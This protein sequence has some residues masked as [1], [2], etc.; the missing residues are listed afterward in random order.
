M[1]IGKRHSFLILILIEIYIQCPHC[2]GKMG[3]HQSLIFRASD[4]IRPG[5]AAER[6]LLGVML[7]EPF[8]K[9]YELV[10]H[11]SRDPPVQPLLLGRGSFS[12]VYKC[13]NKTTSVVCALKYVDTQ[14]LFHLRGNDSVKRTINE[15]R[16][17]VSVL[18]QLEHQNIIKLHDYY[19][20]KNA[21]AVVLEC[22]GKELYDHVVESGNLTERDAAAI[23]RDIVQAVAYMHKKGLVH[24]DLKP[25][26]IVKCGNI[27]K[28][29]DFGFS[30]SINI[31][32]L[33]SF[34]GTKNYA[35]PEIIRREA[36]DKSVD[37]WSIG[38][39]TFVLLV[40][41]LPFS[42]S[43]QGKYSYHLILEKKYWS[44]ISVAAKTFVSKILTETPSERPTAE[45]LFEMPFLN[46]GMHEAN[47][48]SDPRL[49]SPQ[50]LS[51]PGGLRCMT[52]HK[53]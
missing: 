8:L 18:K 5:K 29:I 42:P 33:K 27:W 23:I 12:R 31:Q 43:D 40:G 24:R 44:S 50:R 48:A 4:R 2:I 15:V 17:G 47:A 39:I 28:I 46:M 37:I 1:C 49:Q 6:S 9:D 26:N 51:S 30:R 32:P 19:E 14:R 11:M 36:Y 7:P 41:F 22:G 10:P 53:K 34:V 25:E 35:A 52:P 13:K 3:C 20:S 16:R 38:V 21:M 45:E